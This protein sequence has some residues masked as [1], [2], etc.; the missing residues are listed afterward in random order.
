MNIHISWL[1]VWVFGAGILAIITGAFAGILAIGDDYFLP[2]PFTK[3]KI[4][5]GMKVVEV[6]EWLLLP[7][8]LLFPLGLVALIIAIGIQIAVWVHAS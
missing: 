1:A 2:I 4:H 8:A 3:D 5:G 6:P 7:L